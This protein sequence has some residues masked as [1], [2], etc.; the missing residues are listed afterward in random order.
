[1][2]NELISKVCF[3]L[4]AHNPYVLIGLGNYVI[5]VY[6]STKRKHAI[7]VRKGEIEVNGDS[8][9]LNYLL[10]MGD[11]SLK[12]VKKNTSMLTKIVQ[13]KY[14]MC[15]K[16]IMDFVACVILLAVESAKEYVYLKSE[17]INEHKHTSTP[18]YHK[19]F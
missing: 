12:Y 15:K 17:H 5:Y 18:S 11:T 6:D 1:M 4:E 8:S 3:G 9:T 10:Y 14:V 7:V 16:M 13:T 2:Y 19:A